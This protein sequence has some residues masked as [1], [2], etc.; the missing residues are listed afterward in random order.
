MGFRERTEKRMG[1]I[2]LM[3]AYFATMSISDLV[4]LIPI[5][6]KF[7]AVCFPGIRTTLC[8]QAFA[9][10]RCQYARRNRKS[11]QKR[12]FPFHRSFLLSLKY[13]GVKIFRLDE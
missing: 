13:K 11:R 6:V 10:R 9:G 1:P 7:D 8:R 4:P 12:L 3:P 2:P 5:Y